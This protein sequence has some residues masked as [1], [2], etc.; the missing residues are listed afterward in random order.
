MTME[1]NSN[2]TSKPCVI[3]MAL[4]ICQPVLKT[5][6]N[7]T[8]ERMHQVIMMMC[9]AEIDMADSVAP[10]DIDTFLTNASW[11]ICSTYYTV[12]ISSPGAS[13]IFGHDSCLAYPSE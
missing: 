1:V 2:F 3:H 7:A 11:A 10:S 6:A 5:Q 12:L 9:T 13:A 4:S 8:L